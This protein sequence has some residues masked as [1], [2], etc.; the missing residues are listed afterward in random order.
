MLFI[1]YGGYYVVGGVN[2]CVTDSVVVVIIIVRD[3]A[4]AE[5]MI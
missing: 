3:V 5:I 4:A 1:W 2:D